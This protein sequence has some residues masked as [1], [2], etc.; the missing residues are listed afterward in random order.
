MRNILTMIRLHYYS[1]RQDT[2]FWQA[3]SNMPI[4]EELQNLIDLWSERPPSRY[5]FESTSGE[6]FGAPH[7]AHVGQGQGI[8]GS[9]AC[10]L[11]LDSLGIR[12][13]VFNQID[14]YR[15]ARH[16]GELVDHAAAL[17]EISLIDNEWIQ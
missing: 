3:M 9:E 13:A 5:D 17:R 6:L 8:I 10:T 1:D 4:N 14:E 16:S 12:E 2:P 7:L 11:A 15:H